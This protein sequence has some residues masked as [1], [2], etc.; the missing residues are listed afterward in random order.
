MLL[1][2]D[3]KLHPDES[4][5]RLKSLVSKKLRINESLIKSFIIKKKSLDARHTPVYV[6]QLIVDV[7]NE[8]KYLK[9]NGVSK[10]LNDDL[11]IKK[12]NSN[13]RPIIIGYGPSGIFATKR[14]LEAGL[15]PIV[16]ERGKRIN[17]R[18]KDID[19]LFNSSVLNEDSNICFGEGGAGTFSDGKLTTR[20]KD[21]FIDYILD[22][23]INNGADPSIKYNHHPHLGSDNLKN[24][25]TS[26]T[27]KLIDDGAEFHFEE[28]V[29][30]F[31]I[32]NNK[33]TKVI[34]N[35]GIYESSICLLCI[36]HSAYNTI[37]H[38]YNLGVH[39]ESKDMAI[40]FRCEHPQSLINE[41]QY[42]TLSDVLEPA[43]YFLRYKD[44]KNVYSFCMCPGGFVVPSM[45]ER[46]TILTNGMSNSKRDNHLANSAILIQV[47]T[48]DY[49][50]DHPLAGFDYLHN[51]EKKAYALSNS[52]K[53]PAQNIKDYIDNK[54]N[55]LIFKSSYPLDTHLYNM[56]D[57]FNPK[58]N[59]IF[60]KALLFFDGK[61]KGF[62]DKGIM[63]GPETRSSC[64]CRITRNID[65]QSI[66]TSGLF[67]VGEGAGY[68]G[69]IVSCA[70]D[71]IKCVNKIIE[72]F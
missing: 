65:Y 35:S 25:I 28:E 5:S 2:K 19:E 3:I 58:D 51:F 11:S 33:L 70:L 31:V 27:N 69:G 53:A 26:I 9:I 8:D 42:S 13:I 20:V 21:P 48:K 29:K 60:K 54:L 14:F 67:P 52:Y 38:L 41:N 6:Y 39:I 72:N 24:I 49:G 43:E 37:S 55:P 62:V 10:Y 17:E 18:S 50:S 66:N 16:F 22:T 34:T 23:F 7:S 59:E 56:N 12:I 61:I 47:S 1:I 44:E 57:F 71:G 45:S 40:G 68:G 36:G 15:K 46:K 4:E 32:E 64:P 63:V 30:D